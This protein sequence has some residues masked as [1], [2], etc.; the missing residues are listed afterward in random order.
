MCASARR[1]H[2]GYF[3]KQL[4]SSARCTARVR[5]SRGRE[6]AGEHSISYA[7][8][9]QLLMK[10]E[11]RCAYSA[12]VLRCRPF[13]HWQCSLERIDD[14]QGYTSGNIALVGLE[15][16][17]RAK[18]SKEKV[19][20]VQNLSMPSLPTHWTGCSSLLGEEMK[21]IL[22]S[23]QTAARKRRVRGR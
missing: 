18:W 7:D 17:C 15:W 9:A 21:R 19:L 4:A 16:N 10:Q 2:L 6:A 11:G 1:H 23:A 20:S 8:L 5:A 22:N 3:I 14:K 13:A 12:V